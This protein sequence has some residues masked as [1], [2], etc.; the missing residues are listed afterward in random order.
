[1]HQP[2]FFPSSRHFEG[3]GDYSDQEKDNSDDEKSFRENL[4][5]KEFKKRRRSSSSSRTRAPPSVPEEPGWGCPL[6]EASNFAHITGLSVQARLH[7][8]KMIEEALKANV[9]A[10][11]A[12][13]NLNDLLFATSSVAVDL[14][15][16]VFR[17][18]KVHTTYRANIL[19]K[20]NEIK[21]AT[22]QG[23]LYKPTEKE[24]TEPVQ[25]PAKR[26]LPVAEDTIYDFD[27]EFDDLDDADLLLG[28][29]ED[30]SRGQASLDNEPH[31][32]TLSDKP[33]QKSISG[34]TND[35]SR[36]IKPSPFITASQ[37]VSSSDH[38]SDFLSYDDFG[39]STSDN[40]DFK[41]M[42]D[43]SRKSKGAFVKA[44]QMLPKDHNGKRR[45]V[46]SKQNCV[47]DF[48]SS[49]ESVHKTS[50]H[51]DVDFEI[52]KTSK[53]EK[54]GQKS[55]N[56]T[57]LKT[58]RKNKFI[59]TVPSA[60]I[61]SFFAKESKK[62]PKA[63]TTTTTTTTTTISKEFE[64]TLH[65]D[66]LTLC[67]TSLSPSSPTS[68]LS[69]FSIRKRLLDCNDSPEA[70]ESSHLPSRSSKKPKLTVECEWN[71]TVG[72]SEYFD[73]LD[74]DFEAAGQM[75]GFAQEPEEEKITNAL[76]GRSMGEDTSKRTSGKTS[77]FVTASEML[78]QKEGSLRNV[79][80]GIYV[81]CKDKSVSKKVQHHHHHHS[82]SSKHHI[83]KETRK[84]NKYLNHTV[85]SKS[86]ANS[87]TCV[88]TS[89]RIA[90]TP[91]KTTYSVHSSSKS[92]VKQVAA[93]VVKHLSPYLTKGRISNKVSSVTCLSSN[94]NVL[95]ESRL[96]HVTCW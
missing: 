12:V 20:T 2:V 19:K 27:D 7:C 55:S 43:T 35:R 41:T 38:D 17:A 83:H 64:T 36:S 63:T 3:D 95:S 22:K 81:T 11:G 71:P 88:M 25:K 6:K 47:G 79:K 26:R 68:S 72:C 39:I 66:P 34:I 24:K 21:A 14:E 4:I 87:T 80:K 16:D 85:C 40:F 65:E 91:K 92:P 86:K 58:K 96:G 56:N 5:R 93:V 54:H 90:G 8:L 28:V 42:E 10:E 23:Q 18:S 44:S 45:G 51:Q 48:T 70:K 61:T 59:H 77:A 69:E 1:M 73:E 9:R 82:H 57:K 13:E 94:H 62:S 49:Q 60:S 33:E 84:M 31:T 15:Y 74:D 32:S 76:S 46:N 37:L 29:D 30:W 67:P 53:K 78:S 52:K 75:N 50:N 89:K